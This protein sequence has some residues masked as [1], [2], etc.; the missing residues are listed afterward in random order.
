MTR[1][2]QLLISAGE[3]S[4]DL[5]AAG[6]LRALNE[7]LPGLAVRGLGGP[8]LKEAGAE[9]DLVYGDLALIGVAEALSKLGQ[10]R[11]AL[12]ILDRALAGCDAL[13][14]VDFAGFN[15][16]LARRA[17]RRGVPVVYYICPKVW[18]WWPWRAAG[19]ARLCDLMLVIFDFEEALWRSHGAR[20]VFVGHP[21]PD[22]LPA[23]APPGDFRRIALLPGSRPGELDK[24]LPVMLGA[25]KILKMRDPALRFVLPSATDEIRELTATRLAALDGEHIVERVTGNFHAELARCGLALAASGT[26]S[27]EVACLGVPQVLVY[28]T[29]LLTYLLGRALIRGPW[30]GLPNLVAG[31]GIVPELLQ[32]R[33]TPMGLAGAAWDL[34]ADE[35]LRGRQREACLELRGRLGGGGAAERAAN[36]IAGF[37]EGRRG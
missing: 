6:L 16:L 8:R 4:G 19:L 30:I 29:G 31:K 10:V 37:L 33:L 7:R 25:A 21:V 24:I 22:Y 28:K 36:E 12:R 27:L 11:R 26:A 5:H 34:L 2:Y 14:C 17:R 35:G 15:K 23:P 13:V 1:P 9:L 18:A 3:A 20:A 32:A